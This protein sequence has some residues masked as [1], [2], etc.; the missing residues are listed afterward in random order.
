MVLENKDREI[1]Y[2]FRYVFIF[3]MIRTED[4]LLQK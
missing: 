3:T 4:V 2:S 1:K